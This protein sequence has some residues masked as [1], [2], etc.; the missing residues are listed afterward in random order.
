MAL[1]PLRRWL[2]FL[3]GKGV[4]SPRGRAWV[5]SGGRWPP[6]SLPQLRGGVVVWRGASAVAAVLRPG[7]PWGRGWVSVLLGINGRSLGWFQSPVSPWGLGWAGGG[8]AWQGREVGCSAPEVSML[9]PWDAAHWWALVLG[10][11]GA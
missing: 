2:L 9:G 8:C 3:L 1:E 11:G 7:E 4:L 10:V 5:A 6:W